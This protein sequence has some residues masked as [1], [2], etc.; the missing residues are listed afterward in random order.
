MNEALV[1]VRK[2]G[3]H[4]QLVLATAEIEGRVRFA[5]A[6]NNDAQTSKR[7]ADA[8]LSEAA[9]VTTDGHAGYNETGLMSANTTRSCRRKRES[10]RRTECSP[11]I[12]R[13][14]F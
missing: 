4:K 10:A 11:V 5:Y 12:G 6:D 14:R 3:P 7:F 13:S 8:E 1:G 2:G 9:T